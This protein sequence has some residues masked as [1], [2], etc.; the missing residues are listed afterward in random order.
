[1]NL[2]NFRFE[3]DADGIALHLGHAGPL[4]ERHH[5]EVMDEL[6]P[7]VDAVARDPAI[8]GCVIASGKESFRAAPT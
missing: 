5:P 1:M 4:D 7:I 3:T 8:K 6:G 2:T